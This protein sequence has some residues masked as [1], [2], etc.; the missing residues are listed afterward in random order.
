[1]QSFG[2]FQHEVSICGPDGQLRKLVGSIY[3]WPWSDW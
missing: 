3:G 1:L 2:R